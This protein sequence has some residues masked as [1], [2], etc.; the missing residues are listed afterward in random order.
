MGVMLQAFYW[1][2]PQ[3]GKSR[4]PMVELHQIEIARDRASRFHRVV[5]SACK[6]GSKLEIDGLRSLTIITISASLIRKAAYQRGSVP[7]PSWSISS[8]LR[9]RWDCKCTPI[10]YSI[11]TAART[12][13]N[14][15]RSTDNCVGQNSH[16]R[17]ASFRVIGNVFTPVNTKLGTASPSATCRISVIA[18]RSFTPSSSIMRAGCWKKSV[19]MDSATT[20]SRVTAAGWSARFRNWCAA[21]RHQFQ[22]ICGRRML[23]Q[24]THHRRLA[25]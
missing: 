21:R 25:R 20:W 16:R 3:S 15:I 11:T 5:A 18:H 22:A 8:S 4:T 23:G 17:A 9:T 14:Q 7:R 6:Q 10:S 13:R 19:S 12:R 1:D 24:R 2:C